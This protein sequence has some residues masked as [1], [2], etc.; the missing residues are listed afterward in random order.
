MTDA[1]NGVHRLGAPDRQWAAL[2]TTA[3][4]LLFFVGIAGA[5]A[6][7]PV[8]ST[9]QGPVTPGWWGLDLRLSSAAVTVLLWL[10]YLSGA[11]A[12]IV[13]LR[14]RVAVAGAHSTGVAAI[15]GVSGLVIAPY[16]SADHLSYAAYGRITAAGGDPYTQAPDSWLGGRDPVAFAAQPPWADTVSVYGP[17]GTAAQ[18][19][20]SQL[21]GDSVRATVWWWQVV[22]V[23]SYLLVALLLHRMAG[24]AGGQA[25]AAVAWTAN[26]LVI[27][28][29]LYGGH[30]DL[31][32]LG[33]VVVAAWAG[34]RHPLLAGAAAGAALST[35]LPY[36]VAGLGLLLALAGDERGQRL[37]I[38]A[39]GL[40]G[41]LAVVVPFHLW[42]GRHTYDQTVDAS[43]FTSLASPWRAVV[44]VASL[45]DRHWGW[46]WARELVLNLAPVVVVAAVVIWWALLG[47]GG[48]AW[49]DRPSRDT[50][51]T[52]Q[53][54]RR[55]T[56]Y[57]DQAVVLRVVLMVGG[58]W[59]LAS[60]YILPWYDLMIWA[61]LAVVTLSPT[62]ATAAQTW[63]V[64][65]TA[66]L[67]LAYVPGRVEG[68]SAGVEQATLMVR[69]FLAPAV[70]GGSGL[71]LAV[72][73]WRSWRST[74]ARAP[75]HPRRARPHP[76]R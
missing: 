25:R 45:A 52:R 67:C 54:R 3:V 53:T 47:G 41:W 4:V 31:L 42:A 18:T 40:V 50:N 29:G 26:P 75:N 37:R 58:G 2:A 10:A 68:M 19:L 22:C 66:T 44:N 7:L 71:A 51:D 61:P 30:I 1:V 70:V 59:V 57:P 55:D 13:G 62:V 24:P 32:C 12:V 34:L 48:R 69:S 60:P 72:L 76:N 36:A 6:A 63:L 9:P 21:G 20:A 35:K 43:E 15:V 5:S 46:A 65:R 27:G 23:L 17:V 49:A 8:P 56:A 38:G 64:V 11:A 28:V 33:F 74:A 16:G 73:A 14:C 39:R